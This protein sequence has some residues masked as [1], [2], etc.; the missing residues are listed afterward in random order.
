MKSDRPGESDSAVWYGGGLKFSCT[1]C[2]NCCSG[3]PGFVWVGPDEIRR[4]AEHLRLDPAEFERVHT[5]RAHGRRSLLELRGGDCEFLVRD[6]GGKTRCSIHAVRP[7]QCRTWP[8]WKSNVAA[9]SDWAAS[10]RNC[11]GMNRG[12]HHP[13]PVIQAALAENEALRLPL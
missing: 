7:V 12:T 5:R 2:G 3:A 8:F 1:Q 9:E 11:P 4:I 6:S 10:S 13:L